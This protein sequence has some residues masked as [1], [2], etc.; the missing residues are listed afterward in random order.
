LLR[1]RRGHLHRPS[2]QAQAQARGQRAQAQELVQALVQ[3]LVQ[4]LVKEQLG[5]RVLVLWPRA[6][7]KRAV[8]QMWLM[9]PTLPHCTREK[10]LLQPVATYGQYCITDH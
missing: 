9:A 6:T 1:D 2:A 10:N 7:C 5:Q 3:A 8:V 4:V